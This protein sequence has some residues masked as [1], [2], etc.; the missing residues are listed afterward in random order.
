MN[1]W[2]TTNKAAIDAAS[3]ASETQ[4]GPWGLYMDLQLNIASTGL[5]P[6]ATESAAGTC[7]ARNAS[8]LVV[9][10]N[11]ASPSYTAG[12]PAVGVMGDSWGIGLVNSTTSA[13]TPFLMWYNQVLTQAPAAGG[14]NGTA[15][16]YWNSFAWTPQTVITDFSAAM[17]SANETSLSGQDITNADAQNLA[18]DGAALGLGSP[19]TGTTA[20]TFDTTKWASAT[21][22]EGVTKW[23]LGTTTEWTSTSAKGSK[24]VWLWLADAN[25]TAKASVFGVEKE[26]EI[27]MYIYQHNAWSA[28]GACALS[29]AATDKSY[30]VNQHGIGTYT[31]TGASATLLGASA[32]MAALVSFF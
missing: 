27:N 12:D 11:G 20:L 9:A 10:E 13:K 23:G 2:Y 28:G 14:S 3:L 7:L 15:A 18:T 29:T 22:C 25:P 30:R 21:A 4:V 6:K 16:V 5:F 32:V 19:A 17:T 26:D 31:H 24:R 1:T 8:H